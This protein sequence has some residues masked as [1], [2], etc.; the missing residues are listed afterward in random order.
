MEIV[1]ETDADGNPLADAA[2]VGL[3]TEQPLPEMMDAAGLLEAGYCSEVYYQ[4]FVD[5]YPV[6]W[7]KAEDGKLVLEEPEDSSE[8]GAH[9]SVLKLMFPASLALSDD[10]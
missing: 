1:L 7:L 8:I 4:A 9:N 3:T 5:G 2:R 10:L 6:D